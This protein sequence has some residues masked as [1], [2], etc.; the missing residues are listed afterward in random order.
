MKK[1]V[2]IALLV[3]VGWF[4]V[5]RCMKSKEGFDFAGEQYPEFNAVQ[6]RAFAAPYLGYGLRLSPKSDPFANRSS[7]GDTTQTSLS[8]A[9]PQPL[10]N[11]VYSQMDLLG[12]Q[13]VV[14]N[15]AFKPEPQVQFSD[16]GA[17][18]HMPYGALTSAQVDG[19]MPQ[20]INGGAPT[21]MEPEL[22]LANIEHTSMDPMSPQNFMYDRTVFAPLKRQYG[23]QVDFIRGDIDVKQEFRGWFDVRPATDKDIVT[24]YFDRYID[25]QQQTALKDANFLRAT[26]VQTL[27]QSSLSPA[28]DANFRTAYA[29]V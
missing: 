13:P 26:P 22:P 18:S 29:N 12:A 9:G 28:G 24:G 25:I 8:A 2:L 21:Y 7:L 10:S 11:D 23:N 16:M 17:A 5:K 4:V 14:E 19:M 20:A 6:G 3:V 1:C 15:F 27:L